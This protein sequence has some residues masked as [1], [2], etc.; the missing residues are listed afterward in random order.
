[1]ESLGGDQLWFDRFCAQHAAIL[2]YW[3]L[4]I[5]YMLSPKFAY[6]FSELVEWHAADTYAGGCCGEWVL[7][8]VWRRAHIWCCP[9]GA[10]LPAPCRPASPAGAPA[11]VSVALSFKL[12]P[13]QS[14][15]R[16]TRAR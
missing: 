5:C 6:L 9:A 10:M 3:A 15:P 7:L 11:A 13:P 4:V 12:P 16:P 8:L 2:Y 14:L 1:M